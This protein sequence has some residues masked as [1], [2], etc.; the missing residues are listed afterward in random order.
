M[1][2]EQIRHDLTEIYLQS[3]AR[4]LKQSTKW[5]AEMLRSIKTQ[6]QIKT[7]CFLSINDLNNTFEQPMEHSPIIDNHLI[8]DPDYLFAKSVFDCGEYKRAAYLSQN[9]INSSPESC[10]IHYYSEYLAIEKERQ[11]RMIEPTSVVPNYLHRSFI[12]L[13][14][15]I[16]KLFQQNNNASNDCYM[17]YLHGIVLLKLSLNKE[18][19]AALFKSIRINPLCWC[20]WHQ[21]TQVIVEES[22]MSNLVLPDHWIKYFFL[23]AVYLEIKSN[24]ESLNIYQ[25]LFKTFEDNT[26]I[27]TQMAIVNNNL[28]NFDDSIKLFSIV[29]SNEPCKLDAMDIYSNL[30]YVKELQTELSSLAHISNK[31][32]PYRVETC[33]CIA[34]FYSLRGQHAKSVVYFSRALQLNPKY[35]SAWTLMGHEYI[36]L[37]NT[38]AAI[39]AYRSA[40]KCNEQDYRAWYGLGQAYEIL[41]MPTSSLYY[42]SK[43]LF[44]KPNDTRFILALGQTF[45]KI[46]RYEEAANCYARAGF[47]SLIKLANLYERMNEEHK[48]AIIYNEF[49]TNFETKKSLYNL[50]ISDFANAYKYLAHYFHRNKRYK[51]SHAAAQICMYF[52]ECRDDIKELLMTLDGVFK[53][54]TTT[55]TT[56]KQSLAIQKT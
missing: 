33:V 11:D 13:K 30:L 9:L 16:E 49:V 28:R 52:N 3:N 42:Y 56:T 5:S 6:T 36:E 19:L 23:A 37:K 35:L 46:S 25:D 2:I 10:F 4:G 24:E 55:T 39:Q 31:I 26:Y 17:H 32:D 40:I 43:A 45:E 34:N 1:K 38:N 7:K 41:K 8:N 18:A 20:S 51:E 29:R 12:E 21:M 44:L 54:P 47:S 48:A 53:M 14:N 50:N 27:R 15:H 22:Q